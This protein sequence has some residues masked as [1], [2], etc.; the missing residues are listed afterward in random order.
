[1]CG[2]ANLNPSVVGCKLD[3]RSTH[4]Y[5]LN[6]K[7]IDFMF[8]EEDFP[9]ITYKEANDRPSRHGQVGPQWHSWH[10]SK[11]CYILNI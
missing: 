1:M 11:H 5:I 7:A 10:D 4:C 6:I 3:L 2:G 8:L 9:I